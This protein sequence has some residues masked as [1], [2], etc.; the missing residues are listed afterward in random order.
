MIELLDRQIEAKKDQLECPVCF[1]TCASPIYR[2]S[3]ILSSLVSS[4]FPDSLLHSS[5]QMSFL[6]IILDFDVDTLQNFDF[7]QSSK[8]MNGKMLSTIFS[9]FCG[10]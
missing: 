10:K 1:A 4:L 6:F 2:S 9:I 3:N 8:L 5:F 7:T